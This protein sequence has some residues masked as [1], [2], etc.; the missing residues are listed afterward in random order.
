M[1]R[2]VPARFTRPSVSV[3]VRAKSSP[4]PSA[5]Q[6][7]ETLV[8]CH[9]RIPKLVRMRQEPH[10]AIQR[11]VCLKGISNY[12]FLFSVNTHVIPAFPTQTAQASVA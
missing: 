10:A 1:G 3:L 4:H 8:L 6:P 11:A 2:C 7:L 9:L 12:F 5:S